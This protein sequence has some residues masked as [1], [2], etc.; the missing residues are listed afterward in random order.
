MLACSLT[1]FGALAY[2]R[3]RRADE[4][5]AEF[6]AVLDHHGVE[7]MA[8]TGELSQLGVTRAYV[9]QGDT[10]KARTAYQD[11]PAL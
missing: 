7:P 11:F 8:I 9:M 5:A 1:I 10:T 3:L 2:L 6:R 4:A